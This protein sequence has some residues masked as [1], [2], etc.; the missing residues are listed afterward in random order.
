MQG[1]PMPAPKDT[2]QP[3][4]MPRDG[5]S[6]IDQNPE[7]ARSIRSII[8][9]AKAE[10]KW[11]EAEVVPEALE[12]H[13]FWAYW[14]FKTAHPIVRPLPGSGLERHFAPFKKDLFQLR[15]D[16][17]EPQKTITLS[18]C[19]DLMATSSLA[20]SGQTLYADVEHLIFDADFSFANLESTLTNNA[21][22]PTVFSTEE[23][24]LI[25]ITPEAYRSLIRWKT[26]KYDLVALANNHIL[27]NGEDG[28]N[29]TLAQLKADGIAQTGVNET[30]DDV[31]RAVITDI[32]GIR[33]GWVAHTYYAETKMYPEDK[34]YMLNLTP[35]H[36]ADNPDTSQI[37]RQIAYCRAEGC[38]FV[39]LSLHWGLEFELYPH[40]E[41]LDW[42]R[43]FAGCGADLIVGHH[44]HIIQP[45]E[46]LRSEPDPRRQVTVL[47]SLGNLTP[48]MSSPAT[49]L[50]L[51]A[52]LKLA[53]GLINGKKAVMPMELSL[54]PTVTLQQGPG[55]NAPLGIYR[56]AGLL[57][58]QSELFDDPMKD[59]LKQS[60]DYADMVL[61]TNWR[62]RKG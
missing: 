48:I 38:D 45:M 36:M 61:G 52:R 51:V 53:K 1:I 49:V 46:I 24:T 55:E 60:A 47:Y 35:F 7:F 11:R 57:A 56:L 39:V 6:S 16:G 27:D 17:F 42:A 54:T 41:Q 19:G 10:G 9:K 22:K 14:L 58:G 25:N 26:Q 29:A 3:L 30:I 44:P 59:Y 40:P 13:Y 2:L 20:A 31:D 37:E 18:L 12:D 4:S 21:I 5:F 50:S 32:E 28:V 15:P 8:E 33:I 43:R 62:N 23:L 34:L